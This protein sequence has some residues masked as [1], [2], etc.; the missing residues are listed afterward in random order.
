MPNA[1][2]ICL[3][4]C[5]SNPFLLQRTLSQNSLIESNT[6]C[7]LVEGKN[8]YWFGK[9]IAGVR[10]LWEN[11]F[12]AEQVGPSQ[13]HLK[14]PGRWGEKF[15][16][17]FSTT[18]SSA[19]NNHSIFIRLAQLIPLHMRHSNTLT[20]L[21]VAPRDIVSSSW[22]NRCSLP[23]QNPSLPQTPQTHLHPNIQHPTS[24][25]RP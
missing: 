22:S 23:R 6:K 15:R 24:M 8:A 10:T 16:W 12:I 18:S 13:E 25:R 17:S 19:K 7:F 4:K 21:S 14:S 1:L 20:I 5:F 11:N 2:Q 9:I 3:L